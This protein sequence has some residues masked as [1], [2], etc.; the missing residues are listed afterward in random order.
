MVLVYPFQDSSNFNVW[1]VRHLAEGNV[2]LLE[3]APIQLE[4]VLPSA[5]TPVTLTASSVRPPLL[6]IAT[7]TLEVAA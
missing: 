2:Q 1:P 6:Q 7:V 4:V 5:R 3:E